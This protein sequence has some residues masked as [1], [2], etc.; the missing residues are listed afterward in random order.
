[1]NDQNIGDVTDDP[2]PNY[3]ESKEKTHKRLLAKDLR[4]VASHF[5][6][7]SNVLNL[8]LNPPIYAPILEQESHDVTTLRDA[9]AL[10]ESG[11]PQKLFDSVV[12]HPFLLRLPREEIHS[13]LQNIRATLKDEGFVFL[14][15]EMLAS[16]TFPTLNFFRP[17]SMTP[18]SE[19]EIDSILTRYFI[20][21]DK[22][23]IPSSRGHVTLNYICKKTTP[24]PGAYRAFTAVP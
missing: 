7:V 3:F 8:G 23:T 1:M 5:P 24:Y 13:A 4:R 6:P 22:W 14:S 16:K 17:K 18:Y 19:E 20:V 2:P 11:P 9:K 21:L 10:E 12:A 15:A